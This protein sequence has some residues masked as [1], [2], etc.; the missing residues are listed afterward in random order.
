V[1]RDR[2]RNFFS[3]DTL[4]LFAH[5]VRQRVGPV[6][7]VRAI[8]IAR[9]SH[10]HGPIQKRSEFAGLLA[11]VL[12]RRPATVVEI[13]RATGGTL[14]ALCRAAADDATLVSVDLP[15]GPFGGRDAS[16]ETI[17]RLEGFAGPDQRLHL[18]QGNSREPETVERVRDVVSAIDVLFIDGD[19]T[20]EGV[21]ADYVLYS[22]LVTSG[23]L[24]VFHDIL[25][26]PGAENCEVHRLWAELS[27]RKW[28]ITSASEG[29][30]GGIGL[31]EV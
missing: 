31:L 24:I 8:Q 25:P 22:P 20:Y 16:D 7:A 1:L 21:K 17:A 10:V 11:A 9:A 27:G 19:H 12:K 2:L 15:D 29:S 3:R 23:G 26:N 28:E 30:W 4:N 14:W 5:I 18:I 13:G 6:T